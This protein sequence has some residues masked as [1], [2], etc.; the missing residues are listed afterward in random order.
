MSKIC[1]FAYLSDLNVWGNKWAFMS[2]PPDL[3]P[4]PVEGN[5]L[6]LIL[7]LINGKSNTE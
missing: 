7:G 5:L 2:S 3:K 4:K 6:S 1:L